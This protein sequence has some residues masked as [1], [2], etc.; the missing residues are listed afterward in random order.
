MN[1]SD[2]K[3]LGHGARWVAEIREWSTELL[4]KAKSQEGWSFVKEA[5]RLHGSLHHSSRL[6][7]HVQA[8]GVTMTQHSTSCMRGTC[9]V[10]C[11]ARRLQMALE[12]V[13]N[14]PQYDDECIKGKLIEQLCDNYEGDVAVIVGY[15]Q[16]CM[17]RTIPSHLAQHDI[18]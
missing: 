11:R 12:A 9:L 4:Q 10:N 18:L 14:T 13:E 16:V 3:V 2:P 1:V 8:A 7:C 6:L 5:S 15:V 17:N